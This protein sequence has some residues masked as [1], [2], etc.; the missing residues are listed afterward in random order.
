MEMVSRYNPLFRVPT[1]QEKR[2]FLKSQENFMLVRK[3]Q[4]FAKGQEK[5]RKTWST[6]VCH[7]HVHVK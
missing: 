2:L 6:I 4:N 7:K 1:G 3:I 5:V